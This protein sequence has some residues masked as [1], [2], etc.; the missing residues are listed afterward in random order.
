MNKFILPFLLVTS[1]YFQS[2]AQVNCNDAE[3]YIDPIFELSDL[4]FTETVFA[5]FE[6]SQLW[7]NG[8]TTANNVC[9]DPRNYLTAKPDGTW[10]MS[11]TVI[12]PKA[13]AD[14]CDQR[15][16]IVFVHGG[17]YAYQAGNN[18]SATTV[19]AAI[20]LALRGYVVCTINYR[21]GWD[22]K[23]ALNSFGLGPLLP[24]CQNCPCENGD[25]NCDPFSFMKMNYTMSQDARA[26]HRKLLNEKLTYG[27]DENLVFYMGASTGAVGALHA[28]YA[29]DDM[30]AYQDDNGIDLETHLGGIDDRGETI[31]NGSTFK[32][33]GVTTIAGA[34]KEADWIES[35]DNIPAM[36]NH[37]TLDEAVQYC[38]GSILGMQYFINFSNETKHLVLEG[39]GRLYKHINCLEETS[40][41]TKVWLRTHKGLFHNFCAPLGSSDPSDNCDQ[42]S[43]LELVQRLNAAF[44]REI[45]L[46]NEIINNHRLTEAAHVSGPCNILDSNNETPCTNFVPCIILN[47]DA[48]ELDVINVYPN[49]A[50]AG[51]QIE[52]YTES[53]ILSVQLFDINGLE[54]INQY[55]SRISLSS[56]IISGVYFL[57]IHFNIGV[58]TRKIM[59]YN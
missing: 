56:E 53:P 38:L 4:D 26:A 21:K 27:I 35:S 37:T 45:I 31:N 36:F 54:I 19:E 7:N 30:P 15:A 59:V 42:L 18:T 49:P 17:G 47:T 24:G 34:I 39:P 5:N 20:D 43:S 1:V 8:D 48:P 51:N 58:I 2:Y 16:S 55:D 25:A 23:R 14:N 33:A 13:I 44:M 12:S 9:F 40:S 52:I 50:F 22:I 6:S 28:A 3:R 11:M 32:I 41:K 10:D 46:G 57:R 29:A